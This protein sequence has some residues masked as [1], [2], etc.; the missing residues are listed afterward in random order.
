MPIRR[1]S[2]RATRRSLLASFLLHLAAVLVLAALLQPAGFGP[3]RPLELK[4]SE[5]EP[6]PDPELLV[7]REAPLPTNAGE[8]LSR[9]ESD[10][11]AEAGEPTDYFSPDR[12][13]SGGKSGAGL[14][15]SA[16]QG[17]G[18]GASFF[19]TVAYGDQFVYVVDISTSM[20][21]GRGRSASQASRFVRAMAELRASIA[22]LSAQQSFYVILFNGQTR[23]MFDDEAIFPRM[24]PATPE[25]K[26]DLFDWLATIQTGSSTDPRQALR[27]G[28]SMRPSAL[29]LLSDGEFNGEQN[30]LNAGL[31]NGNPSVFEVIERHNRAQTPIHTI[32]YEDK[33]SC[34]AMEQ[35]SQST[36]GEYQFIPPHTAADELP[37]RRANY[38][39]SLAKGLESRGRWKQA[40]AI[41]RRIERDYPASDAAKAA[42]TKTMELSANE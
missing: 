33:S 30:R 4:L 26:Q 38:L 15:D 23:R 6:L 27:L 25:N 1:T 22:R 11:F 32:A 14:A 29:F 8:R 13:L 18:P 5:V 36:G 19:G 12:V 16:K 34:K 41:Y 10:V 3:K 20:D 9:D 28:L 39:L 37:T 31:L 35:I 17:S 21:R 7:V 2:R 24:L 40:L 42:A